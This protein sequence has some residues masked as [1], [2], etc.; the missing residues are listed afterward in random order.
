[1]VLST[2][3]HIQA[4]LTGLFRGETLRN[5]PAKRREISYC[6]VFFAV[7]PREKECLPTEARNI[8]RHIAP[9]DTS[10]CAFKVCLRLFQNRAIRVRLATSI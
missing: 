6:S 8:F 10:V 1:M 3:L 4:T 7:F 5:N 2:A 9:L